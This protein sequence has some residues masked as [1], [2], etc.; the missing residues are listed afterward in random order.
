MHNGEERRKFSGN[1]MGKGER[2]C[3]D[4]YRRYLD[5]FLLYLPKCEDRYENFLNVMEDFRQKGP[6]I[7][8]GGDFNT[9]SPTQDRKGEILDTGNKCRCWRRRL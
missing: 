5:I 8:I 9:K 1:K 2:I 7:L 3:V 4:S 6:N